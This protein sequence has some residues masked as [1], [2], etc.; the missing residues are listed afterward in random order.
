MSLLYIN[1]NGATVGV[2]G[3]RFIVK[4][5]DGMK[6]SLPIE[7]MEAI[8]IMGKSQMTTQCTIECLKRGIPVSY[9]S[10]NGLYFGRVQST[11]HVNTFRQRRQCE[12]YESEFATE[13]SKKIIKA[14]I[15]NQRVV[16]GRYERSKGLDLSDIKKMMNICY[17]KI[18][19]CDSISEIMGYEGQAAKYYFDGLSQCIEEEFT[20]HGRSRRPP[21]DEFNSMIS[22]GYSILMNELYYKIEMKGLN[23]YFGFLHRD[24][25]KHPTLAS[26]LMEEWRAVIVDATV[27]SMIN[28]HEIKKED[29]SVNMDEP[30]V[31]IEKNGLRKYLNKL[32][33]KFQ[34]SIKYLSYVNYATTF[35]NAI[36]LQ[37]N[38][39][40]KAIENGDASIYEPIQLR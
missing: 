19:Y 15:K 21:L 36:T 30:G 38:Q 27:M 12:L 17:S 1:E 20:F 5:A 2:E 34:T 31:F 24:S 9:F 13:L 35:R 39:L 8:T 18:Q 33:K 3:S 4:Y 7:S 14:K 25:E 22:L 10:K 29:F 26:D 40:V 11:N 28:G 32:E 37:I 16:L 23:P 6:R